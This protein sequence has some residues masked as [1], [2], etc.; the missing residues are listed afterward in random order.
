MSLEEARRA[1]GLRFGGT[2]QTAEACRDRQGFPLLESIW[3]DVRYA[4]RALRR[5]PAFAAMAISMLALALGLCANVAI[6]G[7]LAA[8]SFS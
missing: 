4:V 1:A 6:F 8:P 7:F 5:T 2:L 3:Q